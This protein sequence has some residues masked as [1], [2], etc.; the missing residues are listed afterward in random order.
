MCQ[1]IV[2]LLLLSSLT[3]RNLTTDEYCGGIQ[4]VHQQHEYRGRTPPWMHYLLFFSP[5]S[6]LGSCV[7]IHNIRSSLTL[8]A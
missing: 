3:T 4:W 1:L 6:A 8:L 7:H 2:V 5:L